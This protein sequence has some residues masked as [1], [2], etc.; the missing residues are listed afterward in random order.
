MTRLYY[1]DTEQAKA[2]KAL[3]LQLEERLQLTRPVNVYLAG[4]MAI[5]L[6]TQDR[7]T[8]DVDAEFDA[9]IPIPNDLLVDVEQGDGSTSPMYVDTNY[10]STFALMHPDYR[11]EAEFVDFGLPHFR[12][13]VLQPVDLA[14]SK[15][16]RLQDMDRDDI[17][18]LV[19][20]GLTTADAIQQCADEAV[21][22]FVGGQEMLKFNIRDAVALARSAEQEAHRIRSLAQLRDHAGVA[23]TLWE[24][25][26]KALP[27]VASFAPW[28]AK[29]VDWEAVE[30]A[31]IEE[32]IGEHGQ[33]PGAVAE[34]LCACSPGA[35]T[36]ARQE[37]IRKAVIDRAPELQARYARQQAGCDALPTMGRE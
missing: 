25:A 22:Y 18:S 15:I 4:G 14:V 11:K 12:V 23:F 26:S 6:Y 1:T 2:L 32:S 35:T 7:M 16:A 10:N 21:D 9:R 8:M 17:R 34:V 37:A 20:R 31:V 13:H 29:S 36:A 30:R 28:A 19:L 3:L 5:H 24:K 27:A 33:A